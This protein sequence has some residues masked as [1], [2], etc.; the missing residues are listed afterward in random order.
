LC[1]RQSSAAM[2]GTRRRTRA[3]PMA[4]FP[5][6][7]WRRGEWPDPG[8]WRGVAPLDSDK[9]KPFVIFPMTWDD[10][11][12]NTI[13]RYRA[14]DYID[15]C[16]VNQRRL[17]FCCVC[18][19]CNPPLFFVIKTMMI[20]IMYM[21]VALRS[22]VHMSDLMSQTWFLFFLFKL[23]LNLPNFSN[24]HGL[25]QHGRPTGP[26]SSVALSMTSSIGTTSCSSGEHVQRVPQRCQTT[27][28]GTNTPA[29]NSR[30]TPTVLGSSRPCTA[31]AG[32]DN[33]F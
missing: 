25:S 14:N 21:F 24:R 1:A 27:T 31:G 3:T 13:V 26:T 22:H 28:L 30:S 10:R 23:V 29:I 4:I 9:V 7:W 17:W 5:L 19:C 16:Y 8:A 12:Y 20:S 18:F 33:P 2:A 6:G 32:R 15:N 11:H